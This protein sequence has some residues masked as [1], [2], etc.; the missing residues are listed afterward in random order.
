MPVRKA[1]SRGL[2]DNRLI[3]IVVVLV[4]N[5]LARLIKKHYERMVMG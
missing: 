4:F 5:Y 3:L 1:I 2:I